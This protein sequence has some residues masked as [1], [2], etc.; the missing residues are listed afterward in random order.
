MFHEGNVPTRAGAL[1]VDVLAASV[2]SASDANEL[3]VIASDANAS[4]A[5]E[6]H[7][8]KRGRLTVHASASAASKFAASRLAQSLWQHVGVLQ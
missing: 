4:A 2:A 8:W 5:S 6:L 3:A 7:Q 1:A